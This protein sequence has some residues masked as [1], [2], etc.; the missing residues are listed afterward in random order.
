MTK[1][2]MGMAAVVSLGVTTPTGCGVGGG[3]EPP[4]ADRVVDPKTVE[5]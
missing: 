3:K 4:P 1:K 2:L 5:K